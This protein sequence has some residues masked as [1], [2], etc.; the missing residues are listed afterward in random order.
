MTKH[1]PRPWGFGNTGE[2]KR[3]ILG[4][5]GTGPYVCSVQIHQTPRRMGMM[6]E[7][8]RE[9]NALLIKASPDMLE[10]LRVA[11]T[12]LERK[13]LNS[14]ENN[15]LGAIKAILNP[16]D[17]SGHWTALNRREAIAKAEGE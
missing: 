10:A 14:K 12:I 13:P 4:A 11:A 6:D 8:E 5:N 1:T 3:L 2:G 15:S 9:A 7:E 16:L 17:P